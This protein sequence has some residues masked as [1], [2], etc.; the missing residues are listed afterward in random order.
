MMASCLQ[1]LLK[2]D[3]GGFGQWT[4][5]RFLFRVV[6]SLSYR[7]HKPDGV[8]ESTRIRQPEAH[9][10]QDSEPALTPAAI[11]WTA[12]QRL[13]WSELEADHR[14]FNGV[15]DDQS[16]PE[17]LTVVAAFKRFQSVR[18]KVT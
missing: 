15:P 4:T 18:S 10:S 5:W 8:S 9:P 14:A 12:Q 13:T 7:I 6:V 11:R 16:I 3:W 1:S 17:L 2:A